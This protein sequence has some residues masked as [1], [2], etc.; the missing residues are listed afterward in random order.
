M[1]LISMRRQKDAMFTPE[2]RRDTKAVEASQMEADLI[3]GE[4][5]ESLVDEIM[6]TASDRFIDRPLSVAR[7]TRSD[8]E[9]LERL[10]PWGY[11]LELYPGLSTATVDRQQALVDLRPRRQEAKAIRLSMLDRAMLEFGPIG[12]LLDFATD[13]GL[14]P[15]KLSDRIGGPI[16]GIDP[17]D[18]NIRKAQLLADLSGR[19][20]VSFIA[21]DPC[22]YLECLSADAVDCISTFGLSHQLTDPIPMLRLMYEKTA[23]LVLIDTRIH[24]LPFSGWVR[25]LAADDDL[26]YVQQTGAE[27]AIELQPTCRGLVDSLYQ[28][29]FEMVTEIV[30]SPSLLA[31]VDQPTAYH[32]HKRA[33]FVAH[34]TAD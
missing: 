29:G 10:G 30:P 9:A 5:R 31:S 20:D 26:R 25:S 33:I 19:S 2:S 8:I 32:G 13:C 4:T 21:A 6:V 22:D 23:R 27:P 7:P 1:C 11:S 24:N 17:L 28:V 18:G 15:L 16:V 3:L 34:K 12:S 14:M